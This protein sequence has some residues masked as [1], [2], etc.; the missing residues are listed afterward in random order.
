[1]PRTS[2]VTLTFDPDVEETVESIVCDACA[3]EWGLAEVAAIPSRTI[4]DPTRASHPCVSSATERGLREGWPRE[5]TQDA[6]EHRQ[7]TTSPW[8]NCARG[9]RSS[10]LNGDAK[11][12]PA[13]AWS[14]PMH[15]KRRF[16]VF[17]HGSRVDSPAAAVRVAIQIHSRALTVRGLARGQRYAHRNLRH[18]DTTVRFVR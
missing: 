18:D 14:H 9:R 11:T 12:K 2:A 15:G 3:K 10:C 16:I 4:R 13:Y 17:L 6:E 1:M 7:A 5:P 8:M